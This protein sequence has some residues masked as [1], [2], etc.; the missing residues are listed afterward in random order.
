MPTVCSSVYSLQSYIVKS[1][2]VP[3]TLMSE[4]TSTGNDLGISKVSISPETAVV[5][6]LSVVSAV[7]GQNIRLYKD[8]LAVSIVP[9]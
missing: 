6:A 7:L 4:N 2:V 5:L 9:A 1:A 8:Y 3:I